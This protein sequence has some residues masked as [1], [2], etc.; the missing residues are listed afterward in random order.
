MSRHLFF[1]KTMELC[2]WKYEGN[3]DKV[4]R[5]VIEY[6]SGQE[7]S[8]IYEF[9]DQMSEL[10]YDLDTRQLADQCQKAD[11]YMCDD[12][13][14]YSRCVALI[15]GPEYYKK[16]K[17]GKQKDVWNMEFEALLYIPSKAWA[18]KHHNSAD[19]YP[20]ISPWSYETGSNENG[21]K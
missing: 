10:L 14:W 13:F 3:D 1:W 8:R 4:L 9:D 16:V 11:P 7:D 20:H 21:W 12:T 5:P 6:L 17:D 15:N 18:L 19:K 2:D